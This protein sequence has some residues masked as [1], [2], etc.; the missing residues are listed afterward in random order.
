M[1]T[2]SSSPLAFEQSGHGVAGG[3]DLSSLLPPPVEIGEVRVSETWQKVSFRESFLDPVVVAPAFSDAGSAPGKVRIRNVTSDGFEVRIQGQDLLEE[4]RPEAQVYFL[5]MEKGHYTLPNGA[6]IEAGTLEAEVNA[7][8]EAVDFLQSFTAPP[9]VLTSVTSDNDPQP[10]TVSKHAISLDGFDLRL[11]R[12]GAE[13]SAGTEAV[14]YIAVE[15]S[16]GMAGAIPFEVGQA[17]QITSQEFQTISFLNG[18]GNPPLVIADFQTPTAGET[19]SL[20][21]DERTSAS[22]MVK[23][24]EEQSTED[25]TA[26][27]AYTIGYIAFGLE[28]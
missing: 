26:D 5:A 25:E 19:A 18:Y 15:P 20:R 1:T 21:W 28:E 23:A 7:T 27:T 2:L 4:P 10:V 9:V 6:K 3:N 17:E 11:Q 22:I 16:V 13:A 14:D 24:D 12:Q 8:F